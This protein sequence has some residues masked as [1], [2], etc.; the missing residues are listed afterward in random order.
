MNK[1]IISCNPLLIILLISIV[2]SSI[3]SCKKDTIN[4]NNNSTIIVSGDTLN[5]ANQQTVVIGNAAYKYIPVSSGMVLTGVTTSETTLTLPSSIDGK[6]VISIVG[7]WVYNDQGFTGN[8][9]TSI[10]H[11]IVPNSFTSIGNFGFYYWSALQSISLPNTITNIGNLAFASCVN[12]TIINLPNSI[13]SIGEYAFSDCEKLAT[14]TLPANLKIINKGIVSGCSISTL[15][16]PNQVT[17]IESRAFYGLAK[18]SLTI[19]NSVK[20]IGNE[21]FYSTF[22]SAVA[23]ITIRMESSIPP[24]IGGSV[25]DKSGGG[26]NPD[27]TIQVPSASVNAY[28]T[29]SGWS[30]YASQIQGY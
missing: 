29:A 9:N 11:L 6:P 2:V 26:I 15:I 18:L 7:I 19:P 8:G 14:I 23:A 4:A 30:R 24:L 13:Q 27:A 3:V 21:A 12:L 5:W 17:A 10:Q 16:I 20:V 25:F 1:K 22:G 28:K